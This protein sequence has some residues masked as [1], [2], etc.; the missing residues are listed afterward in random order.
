[1]FLSEKVSNKYSKKILTYTLLASILI[2]LLHIAL[3]FISVIIFNEKHGFFFELSNRFDLNDESSVPQ[4]LTHILFLLISISAFL[5]SILDKNK[6]KKRLWQV[7]SILGLILSIDDV[8]T[9]HEFVLQS[10]HNTLFADQA[11]T[12]FRNAWLFILPFV[13][14]GLIWMYLSMVKIFPKFVTITMTIGGIIFVAGAVLVDS[15]INNFPPR[16][17]ANQ[18]LL[19]A[20]EGGLQLVGLCIFIY[21]IHIYIETYYSKKITNAINTLKE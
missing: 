2:V 1:M 7:I 10:I 11:P 5:A 20:L 17:F 21:G 14:I 19:A 3:K 16:S 9:I 18:G 15:F 6:T 13:L 4:W 8:A 12:A